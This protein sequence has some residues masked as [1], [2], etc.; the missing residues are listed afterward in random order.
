MTSAR[1]RLGNPLRLAVMAMGPGSLCFSAPASADTRMGMDVAAGGTVESN[2][3]LANGSNADVSASLEVTP[4]LQLSDDVSSVDLRGNVM[5]NQYSRASNGTDLTGSVSLAALR[6]LSPY[7]SVS[8]SANYQT[9]SN[10]LNLGFANVRPEDPLP[11]PTTPLP[12]ISFAGTRTRTH[13]ISTNLGITARLSER[14]QL[15]VN[16]TATR[17]TVSSSL[18]RDYNSLNGG[19]NYSRTMSSRVSLT[20]GVRYGKSNYFGTRVGD[21][22]ILT[23]EAGMQ[24]TLSPRF[25]LNA[26]LGASFSRSKRADGTI[27]K[28][29]SLSG[30]ARLC[31]SMERGAMCLSAA[32]SAEPTAL[33]SISTVTSVSLDYDTR[34][35]ARDTIALSFG[36]NAS[37]NEIGIITG[38]ETSTYYTAGGRWSRSLGRRLFMFVAPSYSRITNSSNSYSSYQLSAGLRFSFGATS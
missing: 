33:G 2:P 4:W 36:L 24:M 19:L 26:S 29:T 23:P 30:R 38:P 32:R 9:S 10:G 8:G 1:N 27:A 13:S 16:F 31:R 22:T 34:L 17:S 25:T 11:P 21:A 6:R 35:S 37:D 18:G 20:A 5:V 7:V 12:D 3:Y 28:A 15:G 14:D